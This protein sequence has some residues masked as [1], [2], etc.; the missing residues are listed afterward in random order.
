LL[1]DVECSHCSVG[2]S[3]LRVF[4]QKTR[5]I[6]LSPRHACLRYLHSRRVVY[7]STVACCAP[8]AFPPDIWPLG[9]GLGFGIIC[10]FIGIRANQ[11]VRLGLGLTCLVILFL[12]QPWSFYNVNFF[13][14]II[15][16]QLLVSVV[17][18]SNIMWPVFFLFLCEGSSCP[19][20]VG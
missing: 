2:R 6:R 13:T 18:P 5:R 9:L 4:I 8:V 16:H 12:Y 1:S 15:I 19:L 14:N 20:T 3:Y 17:S 7:C 11:S 10:M